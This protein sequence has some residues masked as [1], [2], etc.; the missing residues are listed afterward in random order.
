[1]K[2]ETEAGLILLTFLKISLSHNSVSFA[3]RR[4]GC[5]VYFQQYW[6]TV[7][8]SFPVDCPNFCILQFIIWERVFLYYFILLPLHVNWLV[9]KKISALTSIVI[10]R[11]RWLNSLYDI[12]RVNLFSL[13]SIYQVVKREPT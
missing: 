2:K 8:K 5:H 7:I 6:V 12:N 10:R 3:S 4:N 1:M 9:K 11:N 13:L